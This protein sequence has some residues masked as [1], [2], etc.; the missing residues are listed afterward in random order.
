M[1]TQIQIISLWTELI[2]MWIKLAYM[3]DI[4]KGL[5]EFL[6]SDKRTVPRPAAYTATLFALACTHSATVLQIL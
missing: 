3:S 2:Y 1:Q 6:T 4:Q 5:P